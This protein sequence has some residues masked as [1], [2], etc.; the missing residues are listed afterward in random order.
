[1]TGL[2]TRLESRDRL[3]ALIG[4][5]RAKA[6]K[7]SDRFAALDPLTFL[8]SWLPASTFAAG[9]DCA[10]YD[11]KESHPPERATENQVPRLRRPPFFR[12]IDHD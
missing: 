3:A 1:M 12:Q 4:S 11:P 8:V 2:K 7:R 10:G 9:G 5:L 6:P